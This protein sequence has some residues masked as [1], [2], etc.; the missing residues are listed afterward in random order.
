MARITS[1]LLEI[2]GLALRDTGAKFV[3]GGK[4]AVAETGILLL[5]ADLL[6]DVG[7]Q[8]LGPGIV[9]F[10]LHQ[11]VHDLGRE[12]V[13]AGIMELPPT[14]EDFL[15]AAHHLD[16]ERRRIFRR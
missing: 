8:I 10:G 9:G 15:R 1:G 14:G 11:L 13:L 2:G 12:Q 16:I 6:E 7:E 4:E 3:G 5:V